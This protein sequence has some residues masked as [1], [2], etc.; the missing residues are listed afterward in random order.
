[1]DLVICKRQVEKI[2]LP[3]NKFAYKKTKDDY[4]LKDK[5]PEKLFSIAYT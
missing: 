1:V 4:E 5:L 3:Y 2:S